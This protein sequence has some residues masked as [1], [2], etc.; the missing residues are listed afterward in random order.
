MNPLREEDQ[1][2]SPS[3][4]L[5]ADRHRFRRVRVRPGGRAAV[6][7]GGVL[8]HQPGHPLGG[9]ADHPV[10]PRLQPFR[11]NDPSPGRRRLRA[12]CPVR[13]GRTPPGRRARGRPRALS[14]GPS[15][16]PRTPTSTA[17]AASTRCRSSGRVASTALGRTQ[18]GST[19]TQQLAKLNYTGNRRSIF[20]KFSEV[21][22][23]SALEQRYSKDELLERYL[24]Q[25][26][27]G[28]G[29]YGVYAAASTFFGVDPAAAH[30]G[31]GGHPGR[32]DP[33]P[34][35]ARPP[36]GARRGRQRAAD[37][38]LRAMAKH[39]WL[40]PPELAGRPGRADDAGSAPAT[41]ASPGRRTSS[42]SSSG[43]P[44]G[45]TSWATTPTSRRTSLFDRRLHDRDDP[46]PQA[47]RRHHGGRHGPARRARRPHHGRGQRRAGRRSRRTTSSAA[48]DYLATQFGY[49]DRGLRQPGSAFKPF[50]YLA[51]LRDGIDPRSTF[52]GTSGRRIP[53][54]GA[55]P[56]QN[57]AG[58]DFGGAIDVDAALA[59]SVNV[60]FVE[61]GCQVGVHDVVRAGHRRRHPRR[62]HRSARAPSSSAG[63]TGA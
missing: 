21:F 59:R 62:R 28:E 46:R 11:R 19:I 41:G 23:A 32:Q 25:V 5:A 55:Q 39:G 30:A 44:A 54:Y 3:A 47:V 20:R 61:L 56:V 9:V 60:V 42:T 26:Y 13:G 58:E 22:Y 31:P 24:N 37:Q 51:A 8:R 16:P 2:A 53:C 43:R 50:V 36:E 40:A 33:G 4:S 57:Y 18:G 27:F 49:A 52:D 63:S 48:L 29:A 15:W 45:S 1:L 12:R 17:T 10:R 7:A 14:A 35:P 6:A 34:Q 38:V